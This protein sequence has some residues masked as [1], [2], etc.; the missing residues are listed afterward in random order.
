MKRRVLS[1][2]P[3]FVFSNQGVVYS[4][5]LILNMSIYMDTIKSY[6]ETLSQL[7]TLKERDD[8]KKNKT[9]ASPSGCASI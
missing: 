8:G 9:M 1:C 6:I 3:F 5:C 4:H 2:T 7:I